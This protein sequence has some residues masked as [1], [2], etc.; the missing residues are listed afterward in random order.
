MCVLCVVCFHT[1]IYAYIHTWPSSLVCGSRGH[2]SGKQ[3]QES[4]GTRL[5]DPYHIVHMFVHVRNK[6]LCV[7]VI[8]R[9]IIC[10]FMHAL[11]LLCIFYVPPVY[12]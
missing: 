5:N 6:L 1:D 8:Y 7:G 4:T 2:H 12:M 11:C 9:Y 3:S 10:V